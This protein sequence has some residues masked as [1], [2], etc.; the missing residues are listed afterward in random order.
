[1]RE[2]PEPRAIPS[3]GRLPTPRLAEERHDLA[4]AMLPCPVEGRP[5]VLVSKRRIGAPFEKALGDR[6]VA[7]VCRDMQCCPIVGP[8]KTNER[9]T[10][11]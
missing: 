6:E 3:E 1:M 11:K 5:A 7:P 10:A 8:L 2:N 9:P 4:I